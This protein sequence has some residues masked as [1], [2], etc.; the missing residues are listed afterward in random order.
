MNRI[1]FSV[2]QQVAHPQVFANPFR[3]VF[4]WQSC[5]SAVHI[6][7]SGTDYMAACDLPS[8]L[9]RFRWSLGAAGAGPGPCSDVCVAKVVTPQL[10][11]EPRGSSV[12]LKAT[13]PRDAEVS[14]VSFVRIRFKEP[15][16]PWKI[17]APRTLGSSKVNN[18]TVEL[19][20]DFGLETDRSYIFSMQFLAQKRRSQWSADSSAIHIQAPELPVSLMETAQLLVT[21]KGTTA[22]IISWPQLEPAD[23]A[24]EFRLDVHQ[25]LDEAPLHRTSI[26]VEADDPTV[27]CE[28]V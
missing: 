9:V 25:I 10:T 11:V 28:D 1:F 2:F 14:M 21:A 20:A 27:P 15:D 8:D 13:V 6:R 26:L 24:A 16:G 19:G 3:Q 22:V 23:F 12:Q 4:G 7:L 17:R 5:H 18:F